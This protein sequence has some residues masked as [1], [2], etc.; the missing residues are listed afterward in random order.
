ML[1]RLSERANVR[2]LTGFCADQPFLY[3]HGNGL[4]F[5]QG[6][7]HCSAEGF[8]WRMVIVAGAPLDKADD[9]WWQYRLIIQYLV[10][11]F[12]DNVIVG[13]RY[14]NCGNPT[15]EAPTPEGYEDP[16]AGFQRADVIS[17]RHAV[18][19]MPTQRYGHCDIDYDS[20]LVCGRP[21]FGRVVTCNVV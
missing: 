16:H 8:T 3:G 7:G 21:T 15:S 9:V 19:K 2:L 20:R 17:V 6:G 12:Y 5:S 1:R 14:V 18:C 11:R 4:R 13:W 10:D